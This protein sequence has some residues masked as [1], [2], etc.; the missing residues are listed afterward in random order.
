MS[1]PK[2]HASAAARCKI[3]ASLGVISCSTFSAFME[4]KP[5]LVTSRFSTCAH[6]RCMELL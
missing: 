5:G 4:V 1:E 2:L 6:R 3:C